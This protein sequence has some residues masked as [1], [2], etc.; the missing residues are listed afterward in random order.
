MAESLEKQARRFAEDTSDLLN[1]T[2]ADGVRVSALKT[3]KGHGIIGSGIS[4]RRSVSLPITISPSDKKAVVFLY[5][6][7]SYEPD[8]EG[9]WL[10]MTQSTMSLYTSPAMEDDELVVGID[11][12]RNPGNQFPAGAAWSCPGKRAELEGDGEVGLL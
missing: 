8:P 9:V 3:A 2:V 1:K 4:K 6:L 10:T 12:A 5:L 7:H 11:Y